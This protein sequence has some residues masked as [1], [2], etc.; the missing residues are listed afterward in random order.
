MKVAYL[1]GLESK[2]G[3]K[4]V[5]W[6]NRK[7]SEVYAPAINYKDDTQFE[8]IL[9]KIKLLKPSYI[10]GSSMGG[11]FAYEIGKTLGIN[12]ILFNPALHSRSIEPKVTSTNDGNN[13]N[14]VFFGKDDTVINPI[15]TKQITSKLKQK[16]VYNYYDGGHQVPYNVFLNSIKSI[17]N[18]NEFNVILSYHHFV[19]EI[20]K[21]S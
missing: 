21:N 20:Y 10:I 2:P 13:V 9:N 7:F 17:I 8:N 4:K 5:S 11:Y 14:Y 1:H 3:G 18:V 19:N 12:T 16:F 15:K 6:L